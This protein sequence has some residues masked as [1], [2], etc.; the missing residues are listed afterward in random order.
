MSVI[1]TTQHIEPEKISI[2][3]TFQEL[4]I[5]SLDGINLLFALENE[6]N[7]SI[8]DDAVQKIRTVRE[9]VDGVRGLVE[10]GPGEA[11]AATRA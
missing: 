10:G 4:N 2:G 5:D 8:P 3:S 9:M 6:F 7:I 1:A 11:P